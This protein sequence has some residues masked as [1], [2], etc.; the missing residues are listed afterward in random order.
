MTDQNRNRLLEYEALVQRAL[1]TRQKIDG[2]GP[3]SDE[4][5]AALERTADITPMEAFAFQ[6]AQARA[7]AMGVLNE[8]EALI[9]YEAIGEAAT[10]WREGVSLAR[11]LTI[12]NLMGTL[13]ASA[14]R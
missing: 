5:V 10:G 12:T 14:A 7:H 9:V 13:I 8:G 3:I 11:K 6:N 4:E 1:D 2:T